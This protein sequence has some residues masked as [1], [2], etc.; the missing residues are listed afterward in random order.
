[1]TMPLAMDRCH[2]VLSKTHARCQ[3]SVKRHCG[4]FESFVRYTIVRPETCLYLHILLVWHKLYFVISPRIAFC[5]ILFRYCLQYYNLLRSIS[6]RNN[7]FSGFTTRQHCLSIVS[8][9]MCIWF[10]KNGWLKPHLAMCDDAKY[11]DLFYEYDA[12]AA[13]TVTAI[14]KRALQLYNTMRNTHWL[15]MLW[16]GV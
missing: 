16:V 8:V 6:R 10:A 4:L 15:L 2:A 7:D 5:Y 3:Q 13:A 12:A 9:T 11:D 1:M 14:Q